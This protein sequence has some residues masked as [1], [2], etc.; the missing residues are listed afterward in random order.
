MNIEDTARLGEA[1]AAY[2]SDLN[3]NQYY[4][5]N[6]KSYLQVTPDRCPRFRKCSA[7]VC[8]FDHDFLR[9]VHLRDERICYYLA[10]WVKPGGEAILKGVLEDDPEAHP[11]IIS[12]HTPLRRQLARA[13]KTGSRLKIPVGPAAK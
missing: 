7:P 13:A 10:E 5:N 3:R 11:R 9:R 8:P 12:R 4:S 6:S 2:K 1:R